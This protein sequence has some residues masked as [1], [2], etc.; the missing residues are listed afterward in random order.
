LHLYYTRTITWLYSVNGIG[1]LGEKAINGSGM[2]LLSQGSI[3][4]FKWCWWF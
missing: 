1:V 2:G 3:K 4:G